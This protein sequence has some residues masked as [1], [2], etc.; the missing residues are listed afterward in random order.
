MTDEPNSENNAQQSADNGQSALPSFSPPP[1]A[2]LQ[3]DESARKNENSNPKREPAKFTDVVMAWATVIM[4]L[5]TIGIGCLAYRQ[6]KDSAIL[7]KAAQEAASAANKSAKAAGQT[8][9]NSQESFEMGNRP[10]VITKGTAHFLKDS[11]GVVQFYNARVDYGNVG[12]TTAENVYTFA[13]MTPIQN[14]QMYRRD[15]S[16]TIRDL[17]SRINAEFKRFDFD[18]KRGLSPFRYPY[19]RTDLPPLGPF[20]FITRIG[21]VPDM[22]DLESGDSL[23]LYLGRFYYQ[24]FNETQS[25]ITDFCFMY[26]GKDPN[27]WEYCPTHN[28]VR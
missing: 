15:P 18:K 8:L 20:V 22:K 27:T 9:A 25:Y 4:A 2:P 24:G 12:K 16:I 11:K 23:L 19:E 6:W 10:Y 5:A 3:N 26:Y 17:I 28:T 7:N 14:I 1:E 21:G 13:E